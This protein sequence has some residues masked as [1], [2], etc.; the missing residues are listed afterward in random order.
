ME[1]P[2]IEYKFDERIL[3]PN[4]GE[5]V[6]AVYVKPHHEFKFCNFCEQNGVIRYLPLRKQWQVS[7]RTYKKKNYQYSK[8]ILRPMFTSYVFISVT[9][10]QWPV[11]SG[12]DSL[13][14]ILK[15]EP[16]DQAKLVS[17]VKVVRQIE[18]IGMS[19]PLE[20]NADI[21]EGTRFVIESG[22]W[23]GIHGVLCKK[24]RKSN[25]QVEIEC[26]NTIVMA[27]IDPTQYKMTPLD[28]D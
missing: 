2:E 15:V 22:P 13:L 8:E 14:K 23:E 17:E 20:F 28:Y 11:V 27:T 25:W 21:K 10:A 3:T 24:R 18:I 7:N 9:K 5:L 26:V 19:E 1:N 16:Q 4:D 6:C 12:S